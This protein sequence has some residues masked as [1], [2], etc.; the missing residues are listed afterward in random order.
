MLYTE[1]VPEQWERARELFAQ[2][3]AAVAAEH[4]DDDYLRALI[5]LQQLLP[6]AADGHI[7]YALYALAHGA[8]PVALAEAQAAYAERRV[9]TALWRVLQNC[10]ERQGDACRALYYAG[11]NCAVYDVPVEVPLPRNELDRALAVLSLSLHR[12]GLAP[13][14]DAYLTMTEQGLQREWGSY[15]GEFLPSYRASGGGAQL[16]VGAYNESECNNGKGVLLQAAKH[17]EPVLRCDGADLV[18]ELVPSRRVAGPVQVTVPAGQTYALPLTVEQPSQRVTF[19]EQGGQPQTLALGQY[20]YRFYRLGRDTRIES[21]QPLIVGQP[22]ALQHAPQRRKVVLGIFLDALSWQAVREHGYAWVPNLMRFFTSGVIFEQAFATSEYTYP[23]Y[24]AIESGRWP[25]HTQIFNEAVMTPLA[26]SQPT[27]SEQIHAQGYYCT[28]VSGAGSGLYQ[29]I[30]RGFDRLLVNTSS[31]PAYKGVERAIQQMEAF[32]ECDQYLSLYSMDCHPWHPSTLQL[33]LAVQ[34]RTPL[35]ELVQGEHEAADS[36]HLCRT[37]LQ[38]RWNEQGIR[39]ADRALG[40]LFSYL[41]ARYAPEEYLVWLYSDHGT[42]IYDAKYYMLSGYHTNAAFMLRGAGVPAR[43]HVDELVS[44]LDIYPTLGHLLG[45]PV[46]ADIDGQLPA[47]FGGRARTYVASTSIFPGQTYKLC[48]RTAKQ[49]CRLE[50]ASLTDEDGRCDLRGATVEVYDRQTGARLPDAA[51][52]PFLPR[53]REFTRL[54]D[55][56]GLQWPEMRQQRPQWYAD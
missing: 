47:A 46:P 15:V 52:E 30:T 10:Y 7:F 48:L 26:A 25:Q 43:G 8:V 41:E 37:P 39:D 29:D 5:E 40:Q 22:I 56:H 28:Q 49:E 3:T 18:A 38:L 14:T 6:T 33:P 55:S 31:L 1:D 36:A 9:N 19:T 34:V 27:L 44:T 24:P 45:L 32:G 53:I 54:I 13:I 51:A 12:K 16:W 17:C 4:Y 35:A 50:A 21:A 20:A 23:A 42:P 2:L 11:L